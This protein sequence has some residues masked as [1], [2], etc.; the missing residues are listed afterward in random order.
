[1]TML[2]SKLEAQGWSALFLQ[3]DTQCRM[4]KREVTEFYINGKSDGLS[5][6]ST[7][8]N[9]LIHLVPVDVARILE[10]LQQ[11]G[12]ETS[13]PHQ[14][15]FDVVHKIILQRKQRRMQANFLDLTLMELLDTEMAS[16][17]EAFD[18]P[19][20]VWVSQ[21]VKDV[22]GWVNHMALP[23]TIRRLVSLF[24]D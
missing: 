7:V 21:T 23:V 22:V 4:A 11:G 14:L 9:T 18:M 20:Y 5:F 24:S 19:V 2:L 3:G 1:M 8:Q 10:I 12:N 6:T 17:F 15:Y 13:Q 16:I